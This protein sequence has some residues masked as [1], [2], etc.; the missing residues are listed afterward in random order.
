[1]KR[2]RILVGGRIQRV[3]YRDRVAEIARKLGIK[4][5]VYNLEDDI[6]VEI[7]AEGENAKI[8]DFLKSIRIVD[9]P[10]EVEKID[11]KE[12]KP[13]GEFKYFK[14]KRGEPYEELGERIDVAGNILYG[15]DKKLGSM[16]KKQ[17]LTVAAIKDM[18][19]DMTSRFDTLD[20][21]YGKISA[22]LERISVALETLAGISKK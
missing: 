12:E 14:I 1:M 10:I 3:G 22:T 4:G 13:T 15:M 11:T 8:E 2:L 19:T 7:I 6:S 18:H 5:T 17:D 16:D 21:K 9:H 20:H